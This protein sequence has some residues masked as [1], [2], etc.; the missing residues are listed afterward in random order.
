MILPFSCLYFPVLPLDNVI[1]STR[2]LIMLYFAVKLC[3]AI[4]RYGGTVA[5]EGEHAPSIWIFLF[6]LLW[7][8]RML[9]IL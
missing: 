7:M 4:K 9:L 5:K 2:L 8:T 6:A 3:L 1:I